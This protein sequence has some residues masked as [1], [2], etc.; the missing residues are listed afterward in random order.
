MLRDLYKRGFE[1]GNHTA[2]HADLGALSKAG[3][4]KELA[5]GKKV[6]TSAVPA[7]R[8]QTLALPLGVWPRKH[9]W[10]IAGSWHGIGYRHL[11]VFLVGA[12]PAPSPFSRAFDPFAIPRV[13]TSPQKG[14]TPNYGSTFWLDQL[15][16]HPE[17]R[18]ISDGDPG[19][20]SFPRSERS[21]LNGRYVDAANPY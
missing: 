16:R 3:V 5:Q 14:K 2:T 21:E 20:V 15:R 13:R 7:A 18:F 6:I 17:E 9:R 1:L 19:T 12:A 10:A 11:G 8:V 4:R